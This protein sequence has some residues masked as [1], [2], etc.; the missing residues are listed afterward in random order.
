MSRPLMQHGVGQLEE[1]FA[2]G[3]ADPKVLKQLESELRYRQVPRAV[4]LLAEVQAAMYGAGSD[5]PPPAPVPPPQQQPGLWER[6]PTR[7]DAVA[8]TALPPPAPVA[9]PPVVAATPKAPAPPTMPLDE[10]YKVLRATPGA[11]WE[12]IEQ[13]RRTVIQQSSPLKAGS[14]SQDKRLQLL[15]EA[16]RINAAYAALSK[17]RTGA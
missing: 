14:M 4:A 16:R 11:T 1:M 9:R 5:K 6:A 2:K 3:S 12:S 13:T 8:L 10:A 15:A 7:E 17:H